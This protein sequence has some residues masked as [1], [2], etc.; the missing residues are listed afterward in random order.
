[1]HG[2]SLTLKLKTSCK[3][4]KRLYSISSVII[5]Q[6]KK[7][8][9]HDWSSEHGVTCLIYGHTWSD[10]SLI[11]VL[12]KSRREISHSYNR[13]ADTLFASRTVMTDQPQK[14][15]FV[16]FAPYRPDEATAQKRLQV[17]ETHRDR[18]ISLK[19]TG[20]ISWD[21]PLIS[22]QGSASTHGSAPILLWV[23]AGHTTSDLASYK[24]PFEKKKLV[25]SVLIF[26]SESL[27]EVQKFIETDAYYTND[28]VSQRASFYFRECSVTE[29]FC[30][31]TKRR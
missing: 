17:L 3:W 22:I 18:I 2:K 20:F 26:E 1:M 9:K 8:S 27:E 24:L 12:Y 15:H 6:W 28:V 29:W 13:I 5:K 25:D 19:K 11:L 10:E 23:G 14:H 16:L 30:S 21:T 31:G 7:V 4:I